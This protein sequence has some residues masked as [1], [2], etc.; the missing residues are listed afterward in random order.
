[1]PDTAQLARR[2]GIELIRSGTW[3]ISTGRW[4]V[5][6]DDLRAA[7]AAMQC[8]AVRKPILKIGHTDDRFTP[9]SGDGEPAIGWVENLRIG[10]GGHT[11]LGDYVGVPAWLNSIMAS[12]YPDRSVEGV[13]RHRCQ[14]DHV[15]PFLLTGVALLGVTPPG[16]GTLKSLADV[17]SLYGLAANANDDSEGEVRVTMTIPTVRAAADAPTGAMVALIPTEEDAQRLAVEGGE[18]ADQLHVTLFYLSKADQLPDAARA[19]LVNAVNFA[20]IG[21]E[22]VAG[23]AFSVAMFNPGRADRE[24]CVV[25]GVGGDALATAYNAVRAAVQE[26]AY[27]SSLDLPDQHLPWVPHIT[28]Q[29]TGDASRVAAL[30]DRTGPVTFDRVRVVFAGQATDV[31]LTWVPMMAAAKQ[32]VDRDQLKRYWTESAEGRAKWVDHAHPFTALYRHLKRHL[33]DEMAKRVAAEW[34]HL[35]KGFWPGSQRGKNKTG[36]G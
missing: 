7:V 29:Y 9:P 4:T 17:K 25:L 26:V 22:A 14:L 19:R 24:P 34:F 15:H 11:L 12:A 2:D 3:D 33:P 21:M 32:Q 6:P 35:V 16:V 8:P 13:Y 23:D 5:G 18:T 20:T 31:P 36:P 30:V 10:D 28:L 1:M 27:A